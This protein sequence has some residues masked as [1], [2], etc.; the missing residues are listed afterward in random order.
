VIDDEGRRVDGPLLAANI[1]V[2]DDLERAL[3][4]L[5]GQPSHRWPKKRT[6]VAPDRLIHPFE[7]DAD[8]ARGAERLGGEPRVGSPEAHEDGAKILCL[9]LPEKPAK[10]SAQLRHFSKDTRGSD[11]CRCL[12]YHVAVTLR[13]LHTSDWHLGRALHEESLL[14]DQA[15]ALDRFV[16][17]AKAERP[18]V[19]VIA[20][21]IYDRAVPPPEAVTLLDD[22][23]TRLA[24]LDV[25]VVA[26]AGN[27]DSAERLNFGAR[28]LSTRGVHLRGSLEGSHRPIAV[29]GKG[30][31]YALPFV[32]PDVVRGLLADDEIRGHAVATERVLERVRADA[33]AR[34]LPTV[35]VGHSFV[36]GATQTPDSERPIVVGTAGS[37]PPATVGGFDYVALGHLHAPQAIAERVQYSGSLLKYSF[38][39]AGHT[40]GAV[41]VEVERGRATPRTISL[42]ARRDVARIRGTLKELLERPDLESRRGDLIEATLDD[43]DYVVDA[44]RRLQERFPHVVSVVRSEL[45]VTA[46]G[47]SF[48]EQV[49]GAGRDDLKLFESFFR[50]VTASEPTPEHR[51]VF[52]EVLDAVERQERGA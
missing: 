34:P 18:D 19:V 49:A 14:E 41:L 46:A 21:D 52:T 4:V 5:Q 33:A 13:V 31:V 47:T 29:D 36:Q 22:V 50:T 38:S 48:S 43:R 30:F 25:P 16:E 2:L 35:L 42:G 20:G 27:H 24:D 39:E 12:R 9:V 8:R 51:A 3:E 11:A 23:L 45:A 17:L 7:Q 44:K 40:K 1:G 6:H 37:I 15:W 28:L 10:D 32:D 26:I